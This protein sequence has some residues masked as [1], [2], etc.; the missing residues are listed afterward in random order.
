[1]MDGR[2]RKKTGKVS[3]VK[4]MEEA[5]EQGTEKGKRNGGKMGDTLDFG[6]HLYCSLAGYDQAY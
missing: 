2:R 4:E 6:T 1:M 5:T 3:S